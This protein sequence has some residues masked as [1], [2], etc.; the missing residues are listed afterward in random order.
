MKKLQYLLTLSSFLMLAP[1]AA[2][3][4]AT[5]QCQQARQMQCPATETVG[6]YLNCMDQKIAL[7][8]SCKATMDRA[9]NAKRQAVLDTIDNAAREEG[10]ELETDLNQV[11]SHL[12]ELERINRENEPEFK[13]L[14]QRLAAFLADF[15]GEIK[16]EV[17]QFAER[18]KEMGAA[19]NAASVS[20]QPED[21]VKLQELEVNL[22][23]LA[24]EQSNYMTQ[25]LSRVALI[26]GEIDYFT[27]SYRLA[28]QSHQHFLE[29]KGY[30]GLVFETE[31][32]RQLVQRGEKNLIAAQ[33]VLADRHK[34]LFERIR[35]A[36]QTLIELY[37]QKKTREVMND[38]R[39]MH[40]A[41]EFLAQVNRS[42]K[43][44]FSGSTA[45]HKGLPLFATKHEGMIAF[46][47][48]ATIC[49]TQVKAVWMKEGCS[50]G[51]EKLAAARQAL[52]Q[53]PSNM[54][55]G[56]QMVLSK[57][58]QAEAAAAL[59]RESLAKKD[60]ARATVLYDALVREMF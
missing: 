22:E 59:I 12:S 3:A 41:S 44:A 18:Y 56:L 36:T 39:H 26:R 40:S 6:K 49:E 42:I 57:A 58:P 13:E 9:L 45:S 52:K 32:Y 47:Q 25:A 20:S 27:E 54:Q 14:G 7:F 34:Q 31:K 23:Q 46:I 17:Q 33:L 30:A 55:L 38:A 28:V 37:V 50:F 53:M 4:S 29:E 19:I 51:L 2:S 60:L 10:L 48:F 1:G 24:Q 21:R 35:I 15:Q 11:Q 8:R 5:A 43:Q 16:P